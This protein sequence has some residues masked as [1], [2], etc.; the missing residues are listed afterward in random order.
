MSFERE[1][2][3]RMRIGGKG[4]HDAITLC[5]EFKSVQGG[6]WVQAWIETKVPPDWKTG[7]MEPTV[8]V[9][10]RATCRADDIFYNARSTGKVKKRVSAGAAAVYWAADALARDAICG[11]EASNLVH[12]V[13]AEWFIKGP[14]SRSQPLREAAPEWWEIVTTKR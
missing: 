4:W 6:P 8:T 10:Q 5:M 1:N 3:Y 14:K 11:K 9:S 12:G 2:I 7:R 13:L